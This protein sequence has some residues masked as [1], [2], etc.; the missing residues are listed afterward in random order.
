[1]WWKIYF[2]ISIILLGISVLSFFDPSGQNI[3]VHIFFVLTFC[4][5]L[6][7]LYSFAFRKTFLPQRFWKYYFWFYLFLDV[8][9]LIY[10]FLPESYLKYISFLSVYQENSW[11]ES[12]IN[13]IVDIPLIIAMYYLS[14]GKLLETKIKKKTSENKRFQWGMIQMALWGYAIV[15]TFFLFIVSFFPDGGSSGANDTSD[16][17]YMSVVFAP[18]LIFWVWVVIQY[19][20]Y[21]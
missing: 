3:P 10:G 4:A 9:Y 6:L 19:Q 15:F 14:R 21:R 2:W 11:Q 17:L 5:A 16:L 8:I 12:V 20:S 7:G 1:M 18:L 13:T